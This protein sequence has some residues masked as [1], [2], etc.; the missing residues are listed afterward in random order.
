MVTDIRWKQRFANIIG[1]K[2][3]VPEAFNNDLIEEGH[4]SAVCPGRAV[5]VHL[6]NH[7]LS[8]QHV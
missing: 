3:A 7:C 1:S 6:S 4:T 5:C 2:D 8:S